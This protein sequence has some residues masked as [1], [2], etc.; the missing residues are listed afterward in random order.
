MTRGQQY[1]CE[2]SS[3]LENARYLYKRL[4]EIGYKPFLND[5][6]TTVV[7]DKPSIK[8]CQKWQLATEGSLAHIVVMQHLSQMK[9]D[10][11]IDDLLA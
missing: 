3:C 4:E 6:S 10:L 1:A 2:V 7:F 5:F 11:F 9:I 8:I